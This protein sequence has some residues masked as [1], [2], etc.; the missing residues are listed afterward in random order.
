MRVCHSDPFPHQL[1][2]SPAGPGRNSVF[3]T[4]FLLLS[5]TKQSVLIQS[6]CGGVGLAAI[7]IC[8][9]TGAE[10]S[11]PKNSEEHELIWARFTRRLGMSKKFNTS[12][13]PFKSR[14]ITYSI[15]GVRRSCLALHDRL[16]EGEWILF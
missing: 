9:A 13:T 15:Q 1:R 11:K 4:M 8:Q 6:A 2:K 3:C 16:M 7:Q 5:I 12:W 14:E 10:V